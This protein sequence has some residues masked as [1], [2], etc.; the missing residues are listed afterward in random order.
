[1]GAWLISNVSPWVVSICGFVL[2]FVG[3]FQLGKIFKYCRS[4]SVWIWVL[5]GVIVVVGGLLRFY[6]PDQHR[7]YFDEDRYLSGAVTFAKF[8]TQRLIN[9]ATNDT[10]LT[11]DPD[12][13]ARVTVPTLNAWIFKVFGYSEKYLFIGSR[14]FSTSQIIF[15]FI[16]V[17]MY[18]RSRSMG[19]VAAGIFAILPV[20]IFWSLSIGL[21]SYFVFFALLAF[22]GA[23]WYGYRP[24]FIRVSITSIGLKHINIFSHREL[25][26][27]KFLSR[28][29]V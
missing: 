20:P 9:V 14:I 4:Q 1:M 6:S 26:L 24:V 3:L 29:V 25:A 21:D 8:G 10:F 22:I 7:I 12:L 27:N 13:V 23:A 15:V 16:A 2:V 5:L 28:S 11:G 19:L 18:L 17:V